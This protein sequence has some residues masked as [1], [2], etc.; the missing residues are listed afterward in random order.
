MS[1]GDDT[2]L[3]KKKQLEYEQKKARAKALRLR[4]TCTICG[5]K[6]KLNCPCG[7]TQRAPGARGWRSRAARR[8][9][10]RRNARP[11]RYCSTDCQRIDW[12]DRGH[13]EACKK[14]RRERAADAA[15]AEAPMPPPSPPQDVVYG[16][17]PRS[18]AD[19]VR[20]RIAAEHEAARERREANP[21]E[22]AERQPYGPRHG[23]RCPICCE[24]WDVNESPSFFSC[25]CGM[26]C[27]SCAKKADFTQCPLCRTPEANDD[28][29][30]LAR[31]RRHVENEVPDAIKVLGDL[32][33]HGLHGIAVN[34]KKA[35][36]IYKRGVQLGNLASMLNLGCLYVNGDGVKHDEK[37]ATQLWTMAANRGDAVSQYYL[38]KLAESSGRMDEAKRW[39]ELAASQGYRCAAN[40]FGHLNLGAEPP[41]AAELRFA[42]D[43]AVLCRVYDE[44]QDEWISGRIVTLRYRDGNFLPGEYAP[45]QI[46]TEDGEFVYAREDTDD[47]VR[48]RE[49]L[50]VEE[51]TLRLAAAEEHAA[52]VRVQSA[53]ADMAAHAAAHAAAG[54]K[55]TVDEMRM[56][57]AR[58][59]AEAAAREQKERQG[60][61][62]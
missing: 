8:V 2:P 17:A 38:G 54:V 33:R 20:A 4:L 61:Q 15:R 23:S 40:A 57:L 1:S 41:T 62:N 21:E 6:A 31:I 36:K 28:F 19:E 16:P 5:E 53:A 12:R 59:K 48:F 11:D 27:D 25:C 47:Y 55:K 29:E 60:E 10:A 34:T 30:N 18:R 39:Y 43:Q 32:Y 26:I 42:V 9:P 58:A 52:T 46:L 45:Y 44:N 14:I 35:V 49:A 24:D 50:S 22:R 3:W 56:G 51:L 37:K 13:R 7:T